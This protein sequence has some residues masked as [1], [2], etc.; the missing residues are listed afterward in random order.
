[1]FLH[2]VGHAIF[3]FAQ[4]IPVV[5][6]PAKEY[7]LRSEVEWRQEI[8]IA[9]GGVL[10]TAIV[11]AGTMLWYRRQLQPEADAVLAGVLLIPGF[12]TVRF[13]LVG[14]GHD[15]LE[16]Q[17]AQSALGINPSGHAIDIMFLVLFVAG[18]V[19]FA[20]RRWN[21]L[22]WRSPFG[23]LGI[24]LGGLVLMIVVQVGN[25]AIFDRRFPKTRTLHVPA[26]IEMK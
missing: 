26:G 2:E 5:P 9:L 11:T 22:R 3:G 1:M 7:V 20:V 14:R 16:W 17:E 19:A 24:A 8:W 18:C 23:A 6:T 12:Y 15:R 13:L 10:A 4:G 25:N 21:S